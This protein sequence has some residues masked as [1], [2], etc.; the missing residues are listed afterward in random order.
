MPQ[1]RRFRQFIVVAEELSFSRAAKRLNIAQP[2]LTAAIKALEAELGQTLI[3]R[4]TRVFGLTTAG[5]VLLREAKLTVAQ[6]DRAMS[7]VRS[8]EQ[9]IEGPLRISF[10]GMGGAYNLVPR[11][12]RQ[13]R[14]EHPKMELVLVK[15]TTAQQMKMLHTRQVDI[16]IVAGPVL[17]ADRLSTE[18]LFSSQMVAIVPD[19]HRFAS[20]SV[21][22][23]SLVDLAHENWILFPPTEGPGLYGSIVAACAQTGFHPYVSHCVPDFQTA[24]GLVAGGLGISVIPMSLRSEIRPGVAVRQLTGCGTPINYDLLMTWR[25]EPD[26]SPATASY[27]SILRRVAQQGPQE[28]DLDVPDLSLLPS[29]HPELP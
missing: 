15:A 9:P 5:K 25:S 3:D 21:T 20:P 28:P 13:L 4:G 8:A 26:A 17:T 22:T 29:A 6:A 10:V 19:N 2:P 23:V 27:I 7:R 1:L 18:L 16:A 12:L 14:A 24:I 11:S